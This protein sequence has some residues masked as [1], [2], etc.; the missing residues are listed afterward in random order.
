MAANRDTHERG[1]RKAVFRFLFGIGFGLQQLHRHALTLW[2]E[3][4]ADLQRRLSVA[5]DGIRIGS[6]I[7]KNRVQTLTIL[8][9]D[10]VEHL[11][12]ALNE[13]TDEKIMP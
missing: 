12:L 10:G 7:D 5:V 9:A 6:R 1:K 13:H 2:P 4:S 11:D 3:I 8:V